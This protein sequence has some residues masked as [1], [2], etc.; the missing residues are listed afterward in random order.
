[1]A[2]V[3]AAATGKEEE[4]ATGCGTRWRTGRTGMA[5]MEDA[6]DEEEVTWATDAVATGPEAGT[7]AGSSAVAEEAA[8]GADR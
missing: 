7:R 8:D 2:E 3:A 5:G 6:E 4:V 1:V